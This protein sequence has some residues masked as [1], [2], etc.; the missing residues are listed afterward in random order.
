MSIF[1]DRE[2]ERKTERDD[3]MIVKY[4]QDG[5]WNYID[6]VFKVENSAILPLEL[7][8]QYDSKC[9]N[10]PDAIIP[11]MSN[12]A[13]I[14]VTEHQN[15]WDGDVRT[16]NL[17]DNT[18]IESDYPAVIIK[19]HV[20]PEHGE[21]KNKWFDVANVI[22]LVTNQTAYLMNDKGQTIERLV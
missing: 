7:V 16:Y 2:L 20:D 9:C 4:L 18:L 15:D 10:T 11:D 21:Y 22:A 3:S 14:K 6:H 5:A 17:L 1:K 12:K 19:I 8:K 13:F